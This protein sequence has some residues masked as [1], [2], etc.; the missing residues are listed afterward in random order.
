MSTEF[1]EKLIAAI[2]RNRNNVNNFV[3]KGP[4]ERDANGNFVQDEFRL[5]DATEE[6][7][8]KAHNHC[9]TMLFNTD[10]K[11]PGRV[12]LLK[13]ISDQRDRCG[14]ELFYRDA[15]SRKTTRFAIVDALRSA[16]T[17]A[18]LTSIEVEDLVIGSLMTTNSDF[19]NLPVRLVIDG[20]LDKL[21]RF[22]RSHITLTFILKQGLWF[23]KQELKEFNELFLK[24]EK[25]GDRA[26]VVKAKLGLPADAKLYFNALGLTYSELKSMLSLKN[27]KYSE[28]TVEQLRTLRSKMLFAL[29]DEVSFHISQWNA[30]IAQ[31]E[32]VAT[33]KEVTL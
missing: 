23:E 8:R 30:R 33:S 7:L 14:V 2:D 29:E 32:Q 5:V 31:I 27:K 9:K 4:K 17:K 24:A 19:Q 10:K 20:G 25:K 16:I 26:G 3:W 22:D 12:N 21:G 28:L 15:E 6:Q 18:N 13:E 11:Y 1:G